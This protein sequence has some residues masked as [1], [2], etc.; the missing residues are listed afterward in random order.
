MLRGRF[1][2]P[3]TSYSGPLPLPGSRWYP[4]PVEGILVERLGSR[5]MVFIGLLV[6]GGGF[7]LFSRIDELWQLYGV[8]FLM[9]LGA[10]LG[11]WLPMM[12]VLNHWFVK[13]RS[14]AMGLAMEGNAVVQ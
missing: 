4:G 14:K 11:T 3:Q 7:L 8:F 13:H 10:A 9:S 5:R 2:W 1:G 6:L 12:T